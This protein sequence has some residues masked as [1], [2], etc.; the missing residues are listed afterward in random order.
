MLNG[1]GEL[2]GIPSDATFLVVQTIG[3]D[4]LDRFAVVLYPGV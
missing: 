3:I 4:V 2:C 1:P